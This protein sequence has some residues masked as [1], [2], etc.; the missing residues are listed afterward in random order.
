MEDKKIKFPTK[1]E[2]IKEL[3]R[4]KEWK[5]QWEAEMRSRLPEIEEQLRRERQTVTSD[6]VKAV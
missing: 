6:M 4:Y 2:F 5:K 3:R 1:E